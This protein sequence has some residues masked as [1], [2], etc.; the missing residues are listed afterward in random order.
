M[1]GLEENKDQFIISGD[2][3]QK[4]ENNLISKSNTKVTKFKTFN[5][6]KR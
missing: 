1:K 4:K 5:F 3:D 6:E 2:V